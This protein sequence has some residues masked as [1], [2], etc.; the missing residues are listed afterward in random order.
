MRVACS[1]IR[2]LKAP[3]ISRVNAAVEKMAKDLEDLSNEIYMDREGEWIEIASLAYPTQ[4]DGR[5][6]VS[7]YRN[8]GKLTSFSFRV[9][10]C[11]ILFSFKCPGECELFVGGEGQL[12]HLMDNWASTLDVIKQNAGHSSKLYKAAVRLVPDSDGHSK[13]GES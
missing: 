5:S 4:L 9:G 7:L 12:A 8:A 2:G 1:T 6:G 13:K 11:E 3:E 10:Y